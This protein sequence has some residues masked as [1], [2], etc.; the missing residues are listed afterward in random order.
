[1]RALTVAL[2]LTIAGAAGAPALAQE[3][4]PMKGS[5]IGTWD[6]NQA[7]GEDVLFV[8]VQGVYMTD[9]AAWLVR[10]LPHWSW[11]VQ[12]ELAQA[13]QAFGEKRAL[14]DPDLVQARAAA[15]AAT[16]AASRSP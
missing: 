1:M 3:G 6:S 16:G 14:R 9:A 10:T 2:M 4:H 11:R 5:W 15:A 7:H 8:Q 13:G 12:Q